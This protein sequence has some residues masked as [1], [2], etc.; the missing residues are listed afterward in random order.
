MCEWESPTLVVLWKPTVVPQEGKQAILL[1][2]PAT[3]A[4]SP[5]RGGQSWQY[6]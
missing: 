6:S 4:G 2:L 3:H 1:G 5:V